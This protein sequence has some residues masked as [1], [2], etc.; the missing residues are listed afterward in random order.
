MGSLGIH[1]LECWRA[2]HWFRGTAESWSQ[3]SHPRQVR[4]AGSLP[5]WRV[6]KGKPLWAPTWGQAMVKPPQGAVRGK[7]L[8]P[9]GA[10]H[11][12]CR[13]EPHPL[14]EPPWDEPGE[15]RRQLFLLRAPP[16]P[17]ADEVSD[18]A[19]QQ[20]EIFIVST[21]IIAGHTERVDLELR[22]NKL[23]TDINGIWKKILRLYKDTNS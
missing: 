10:G 5:W 20:G 21:S 9:L 2:G 4:L 1:Q 7:L 6:C 22:G 17:S 13:R 23:I 14:K 16:A 18:R 12:N 3:S 11:Q 8:G 19:R 15:Q